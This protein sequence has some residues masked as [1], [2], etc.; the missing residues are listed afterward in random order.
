M[1]LEEVKAALVGLT[2]EYFG[3]AHVFY[4]E[5]K[6]AKSVEP[7]I[8]VQ[9]TSVDSVSDFTVD[10]IE[11]DSFRSQRSYRAMFDINLYTK[12]KDASG[13]RGLPVYIN[14]SLENMQ[15]FIDFL[16]SEYI[17]DFESEKNI[18]I[19]VESDVKDLSALINTNEYQYRSMIEV[20]VTFADSRKGYMGQNNVSVLP[21]QS[22][23]GDIGMVEDGMVIEQ[24]N[25]NGDV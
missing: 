10:D 9:N 6:K 15:D 12:G 23:G 24:V 20:S 4:A 14:S 17:L 11:D 21:N 19:K 13:G 7:Y 5:V 8:T 1:K 3:D 25:Y 22:G 18:S 2:A 16:E